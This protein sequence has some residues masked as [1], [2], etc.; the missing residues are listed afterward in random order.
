MNTNQLDVNVPPPGGF[1]FKL[2]LAANRRVRMFYSCGVDD[3][4]AH[5]SGPTGRS[6]DARLNNAHL[7]Y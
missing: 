6:F 2:S 5:E 4:R 7:P 1:I 3:N